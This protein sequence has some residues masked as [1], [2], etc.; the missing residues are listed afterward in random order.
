MAP[1]LDTSIA[2]RLVQAADRYGTPVYVTD[3]AA[4]RRHAQEVTD[5]FPDPWIRQY[6]VKA[7]DV[8]AVIREIAACGFGAN[9]VSRGEWALATEAGVANARITF[10]GIGKTDADMQAVVR[11]SLE[12]DPIRWIAIESVDEAAALAAIAREAGLG[13]ED[14]RHVDTLLRLNPEIE[15]ETI[16][17]LAV[18]RGSSK[19]G[20][21]EAEIEAAIEAGGGVGGPPRWRGLH[22]HAGSQLRSLDA[23]AEAVRRV[24]AAYRTWQTRLP[25]FTVLDIGGGFPVGDD[26]SMPAPRDFARAFADAIAPL[27]AAA[28]PPTRA[29]EPGRFLVARAGYIVSRVL[30]A[31]ERRSA[32]GEPLVVIDAGMTEIIRPALYQ[33]VH[34]IVALMPDSSAAAARPTM[35]E[36]PICESTDRLGRHPL[37]PLRRGDLVAILDAG[38]YASS[39]SSRYNGRPRPPEVLIESDGRLRLGRA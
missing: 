14:A 22:L 21:R 15:P 9:V 6:S 28:R 36:G 35:V 7:N 30:H 2:Q 24:L 1:T 4:L 10:E 18:G 3:V 38:A 11:A 5:A 32:G 37:P 8:P 12:G 33:A 16:A 26:A 27:A 25:E 23:W 19:F 39:M 13:P 34:P 29:I 17:G 31:R 20:L